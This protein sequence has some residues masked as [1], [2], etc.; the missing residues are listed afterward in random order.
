MNFFTENARVLLSPRD[1]MFPSILF[2]LVMLLKLFIDAI[3]AMA[4]GTEKQPTI[5][6]NLKKGLNYTWMNEPEKFYTY[7]AIP[8]MSIVGE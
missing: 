1:F 8:C 7:P 6:I 2:Y 4:A 3:S 5:Y